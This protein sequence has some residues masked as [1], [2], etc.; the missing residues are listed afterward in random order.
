MA[1]AASWVTPRTRIQTWFESWGLSRDGKHFFDPSWISIGKSVRC[2][3]C[4]CTPMCCRRCISCRVHAWACHPLGVQFEG[5]HMTPMNA[6]GSK[7]PWQVSVSDVV[8]IS[9]GGSGVD[10]AIK[11]ALQI[12]LPVELVA[13]KLFRELAS[14]QKI[15]VLGI[16]FAGQHFTCDRDTV[17]RKPRCS[18]RCET[19][20]RLGMNSTLFILSLCRGSSCRILDRCWLVSCA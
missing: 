3:H 1:P 13:A 8:T 12:P 4:D 10:D 2:R 19:S 16:Q 6:A 9:V 7:P 14:S 15:R 17:S 20:P 11:L 5:P 18:K